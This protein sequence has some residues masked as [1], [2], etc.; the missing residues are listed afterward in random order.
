MKLLSELLNEYEKDF[1]YNKEEA[2]LQLCEDLYDEL[3][4]L[5]QI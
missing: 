2:Y 1:N 5:K 4:I 3:K